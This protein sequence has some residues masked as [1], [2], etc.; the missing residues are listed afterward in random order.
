MRVTNVVKTYFTMG[1]K[2]YFLARKTAVIQ[3]VVLPVLAPLVLLAFLIAMAAIMVSNVQ[4]QSDS[5]GASNLTSII[6]VVLQ[7]HRDTHYDAVTEGLRSLPIEVKTELLHDQEEADRALLEDK[8]HAVIVFKS[9]TP[10]D[11]ELRSPSQKQ[12]VYRHVI[13]AIDSFEFARALLPLQRQVLIE[14][15]VSAEIAEDVLTQGA[16]KKVVVGNS[17][18]PIFALVLAGIFWIGTVMYPISIAK[19]GI[20]YSNDIAGDDISHCLSLKIPSVYYVV[21]RIAGAFAVYLPASLIMTAIVLSYMA[22]LKVFLT[23]SLAVP[24]YNSEDIRVLIEQYLAWS[25][26]FFGKSIFILPVVVI[27]LGIPMLAINLLIY[28]YSKDEKTAVTYSGYL[29]TLSYAF[30][31]FAVFVSSAIPEAFALIPLL[32][33]FYLMRAVVVDSLNPGF[34]GL[35]MVSMLLF[36]LC[37]LWAA[38]HRAYHPARW[39]R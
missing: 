31:A 26:V 38:S 12:T 5:P 19:M 32:Q 10:L 1:F 35:Y 4:I 2:E 27:T 29:D 21:S 18:P 39:L 34:L 30:P 3:L 24:L 37:V 7:E 20:F 33:Q 36:L 22:F 14:R 16:F 23:S 17:R 25:Q 11:I 15:G 8:V 9:I 28:F 13:N 6:G